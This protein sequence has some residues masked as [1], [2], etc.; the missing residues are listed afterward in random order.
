MEVV[1]RINFTGSVYKPYFDYWR[2]FQSQ[3]LEEFVINQKTKVPS[4][5]APLRKLFS[6]SPGAEE[7]Y[8]IR[9]YVDNNDTGIFIMLGAAFGILL[10]NYTNQECI[11]I[12]T[13]LYKVNTEEKWVTNRVPLMLHAR[14]D[15]SVREYLSSCQATIRDAYVYQNF[16]FEMLDDSKSSGYFKTQVLLR[17]DGLHEVLDRNDIYTLV[18]NV[19][20]TNEQITIHL[21]YNEN[22]F[23]DSFIERIPEHLANTLCAFAHSDQKI[24]AINILS[25]EEVKLLLEEFN[26][27]QDMDFPE[28]TITALFKQQGN[29]HPGGIAVSCGAEKLSY[30]ELDEQS[31]LLAHYIKSEFH[32]K[33]DDVVGI[34]MDRGVHSIVAILA[35]L[36]AGAAF[37]PIDTDTPDERIVYMLKDA[38][39]T[40]LI[41][42]SSML[43]RL[44]GHLPDNLFVMDIQWQDLHG[45]TQN[46]FGIITPNDLAYIIYTSGSTGRPKGVMIEHKSV[47]NMSGDQIRRFG[48]KPDD[49]VLQFASLSFDAS[50]YE[51]FMALLAG[52]TLVIVTK[53]II[54]DP[55][56]FINY[57]TAQQVTVVTLPPVYLN[58]LDEDRIHFLRV[59]ITAGEAANVS[60]AAGLS[61]FSRYFN[62]YG[63]TECAVCVSV[64]EVR[65]ADAGKPV[66]PIGK[67]LNN[68]RIY[69]MT[70]EGQLAPVGIKGEI[71]VSGVGVARG[72][73]NQLV[74]TA[75]KF[76]EDPFYSGARLYRTGDMGKWLPDGNIEFHGR[77]D[78]QVKIN[79]NRVETGEIE[80]IL[81]HQPGVKSAVV[82]AKQHEGTSYL[83]AYIVACPEPGIEELRAL[84]AA[85]LP[86]YMI[87][88][89]WS[90]IEEIP[91]NLNGKID[92]NALPAPL[93][94]ACKEKIKA[95]PENSIQKE[96]VEIWKKFFRQTSIG[97]DED[98]FVLGGDSIKAIQIAAEIH[99]VFKKTVTIAEIYSSSTIR[100][101][102]Q[103]IEKQQGTS[104][105]NENILRGRKMIDSLRQTMLEQEPDLIPDNFEDIYP[106]T[107]IEA[108]MIYSSLLQP[109]EPVYYD[110][111]T[112]HLKISSFEHF[113]KAF[114]VLIQRH[115]N[116]RAR[117]FISGFS[118]P[119]KIVIRDIE[120]PISLEE[121]R[122]LPVYNQEKIIKAAIQKDRLRRLS[123]SGDLL[124]QIIAFRLS[125][126]DYFI[127]WSAHHSLMDGWSENSIRTEMSQ[128]LSSNTLPD[129]SFFTPLAHSYK[130]YCAWVL[131]RQ[132]SDECIQ[133]WRDYLNGYTRNKLPFNYTGQKHA[134]AGGMLH[135]ERV[136]DETLRDALEDLAVQQAISFKS[137]CVAAHIYLMYL[138]CGEKDVVTGIVSHDRPAISDGDRIVGCFLNTIPV[139]LKIEEGTDSL[140]FIR[141]VN[142]LL[143][144]VKPY[145]IHLGDIARVVGEKNMAS[146]PIFDCILNYTDFYILE[147]GIQSEG[148]STNSNVLNRDGLDGFGMTNTLFDVE[149]NKTFGFFKVAIKYAPAYFDHIE[150]EYATELYERILDQFI[151][152]Q[153]LSLDPSLLSAKE[154]RYLLHDFNDTAVGY[155]ADQTL[156]QQFEKQVLSTPLSTALRWKGEGLT[157]EALNR[158]AN[159]IAHMLLAK[160]VRNGDNIGL[161]CGRGFEMI[162]GMYGILKA[163]CAYVPIDPVYPLERQLY[164]AE[165]SR[166]SLLLTDG[167]Y[168]IASSASARDI[169]L[170][171]I[172]IDA[173]LDQY[174]PENP[175]VE[176]SSRD[177]AYTIYTSGSTGRPKGVMIEHHSAV[178]LCE[179]VNNEF[180]IGSEDRLLFITSMC[181]DLSVYDIFGTL[182]AGG[183]VVIAGQEDIQD[184]QQLQA[185]LV[186]ERITFWDSVPTT[187]HYL[188]NELEASAIDFKQH[189]LRLVFMSGDW[190]P[191]SLANRLRRYFPKA[192][193]ISLGGATEGTV[194]SNYYPI[195]KVDEYWTSIPYG[196]PISNNLFYI[197]DE[198]Q[199][200]VPK[201]VVGELYI[202]GVGVARDYANDEQKTTASFMPDPFRQDLGGRMYRTG[203]LGRM[204]P[205][206]NMEFLGRK[207]HQVKIRGYRVELGEIEHQLHK[208]EGIQ[209]A[210]VMCADADENSRDKELIAYIVGSRR[211]DKALLN[212]YLGNILPYYMVPAHIIQLDALPLNVNGKID[213][214]ALAKMKVVKPDVER[215]FRG[216]RTD[217]EKHLSKIWSNLI[218]KDHISI[219][220]N[221]F[222]I[223][224]D[225]L[226]LIRALSELKKT[227]SNRI[228]ITD[229]FTHYTIEKLATYIDDMEPADQRLE[230]MM[231]KTF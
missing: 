73:L 70:E 147:E 67:P 124:W 55:D 74:F 103:L 182:S 88:A 40:A 10:K 39:I 211:I 212:A 15:M 130:D 26:D 227:Y 225:S 217:T 191:V 79:G 33:H 37:L 121:L 95:L 123:F 2:Q 80:S 223:G 42:E 44:A 34:L 36:K 210:V 194:W 25:R 187:M 203:D 142:D 4:S 78:N 151:R 27:R 29:N 108:G 166:V 218:V 24:G 206:G 163:G 72:Y 128:L 28:T 127:L 189:Y 97:I 168:A 82:V 157:Y 91:V 32:I 131:G 199:R 181:F 9:S 173:R 50:V 104:V 5:T 196:R 76:S 83:V 92:Y 188:V 167:D 85:F 21:S 117:Y 22:E 148:L 101:L 139:R 47:V 106:I 12:D 8:Q 197:L 160:G 111:F 190:I 129:V 58:L 141:Q 162:A 48:I 107:P 1:D 115:P 31:D 71:C 175:G 64:Y 90:F 180:S 215:E 207:D 143:I 57:I 200:P 150:V 224:A 60:K 35:V 126:E 146:N 137:L 6:F 118:E 3:Y 11:T 193:V 120:P 68:L 52:A 205:D 172:A 56:R 214:N 201:G 192:R 185:L 66:I 99:Q 135:V 169:G 75:E 114:C 23:E 202:G 30:F 177:L 178:N 19:E 161:L 94:E 112:F 87:P 13:P 153:S 61:R 41:T 159:Q 149:V 77:K 63:P 136:L 105:I 152:R 165:N 93:E 208:Y 53:D 49:K 228:G 54:N 89:H 195:E 38:G 176:K 110:Q 46:D 125:S 174:S 45:D 96:L 213:I 69:I 17:Y 16:S 62:A 98:Y 18:I 231:F 113:K 204:L 158:Q 145:E 122:A 155:S 184:V 144:K 20:N 100:Q 216:P 226:R 220:D 229:L 156:H 186:Q 81:L 134:A 164:I 170:V 59:I 84:L 132:N 14:K 43:F 51:T 119:V 154:H 7:L 133:F 86:V 171:C 230:N 209:E 65:S 138:L 140:S 109:D 219:T 102:S 222:E 116:F 179:W 183:T 198:Q 221:F